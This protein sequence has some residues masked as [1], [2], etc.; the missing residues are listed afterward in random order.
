MVNVMVVYDGV[1]VPVEVVL[2]SRY[3]G[4]QWS[5]LVAVTKVMVVVYDGDV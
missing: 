5:S 4:V 3:G 2:E 1:V